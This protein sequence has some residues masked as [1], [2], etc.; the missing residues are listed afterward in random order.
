MI[1][2]YEASWHKKLS[3]NLFFTQTIGVM[4]RK[5]TGVAGKDTGVAGDDT[6]VAGDDH[7]GDVILTENVIVTDGV[8]DI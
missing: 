2:T 5:E 6:G 1:I 8:T 4:A 7:T 3:I